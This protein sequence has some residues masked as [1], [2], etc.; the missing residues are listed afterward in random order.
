MP[1]ATRVCPNTPV[2]V[3]LVDRGSQ[4][5]LFVPSVV[6]GLGP[7]LTSQN[8]FSSLDFSSRSWSWTRYV[9]WPVSNRVRFPTFC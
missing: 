5:V 2:Y 1:T 8:G 3:W 9:V 4:S 6:N 7:Q